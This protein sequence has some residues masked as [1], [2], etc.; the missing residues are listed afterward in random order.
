MLGLVPQV[1]LVRVRR[2]LRGLVGDVLLERGLLPRQLDRDAGEQVGQL[3]ARL[4][5]RQV[6]R[7]VSPPA[8]TAA[9][10]TVAATCGDG[11]ASLD[12][13]GDGLDG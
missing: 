3:V 7:S 9:A 6:R 10:A 13:L 8:A 11:I 4:A 1:V 12:E 2:Y 5:R